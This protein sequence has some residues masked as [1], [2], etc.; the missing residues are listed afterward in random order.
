MRATR[1]ARPVAGPVDRRWLL[2]AGR[3]VLIRP[4]LWTIALVQLR[5]L[6]APGWWRGRPFLPL[7]DPDYLRFRLQTMYGGD[8]QRQPDVADLVTYLCWC[9]EQRSP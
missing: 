1:R 2:D 3:A 8:E 4:G 5:R 9:K 6:A 7:P